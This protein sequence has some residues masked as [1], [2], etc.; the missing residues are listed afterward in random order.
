MKFAALVFL[1]AV[2]G[3]SANSQY[4]FTYNGREYNVLKT[5][6]FKDSTGRQ[7]NYDEAMLEMM[8]GEY[9]I[10]PADTKDASKGFLLSAISKEEQ[11]KRAMAAPKP[12]ESTAFKT[13]KKINNISAHD[14]DGNRI[15]TKELKGKVIVINFWF[16]T[17]PPCRAER[18]YLNKI[19]DD[20]KSDS[21]I[22][23]LAI[24]LD[25]KERLRN[26]LKEN[27]FKYNVIP[28]GRQIVEDLK[29]T[30]Y[31]T[32]LILDKEGKVAFHAVSYYFVTDY[33]MRKTI[34]ELKDL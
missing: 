6:K 32:Q 15:D 7:F 24:A 1:L 14:M 13:G 28:E 22:V 23:F 27:E 34:D 5:S 31:P 12:K 30:S 11:L 18:P 16:T 29:V 21:N 2:C 8:G 19:V 4:S 33:W 10:L 20:Y 17:C 9:A 3:L 25:P 26:Y